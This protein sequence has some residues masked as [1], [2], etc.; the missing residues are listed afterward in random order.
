VTRTRSG[1]RSG[2]GIRRTRIGVVYTHGGY[3]KEVRGGHG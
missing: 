1:T 2:M 3:R